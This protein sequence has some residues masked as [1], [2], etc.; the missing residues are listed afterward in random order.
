VLAYLAVRPELYVSWTPPDEGVLAQGA[1]RVMRGE[2]PHRDFVA[3]WSGGLDYLN[4]AAFRVLGPRLATLRTVVAAAWLLGLAAMFVA[5]R[6]VLSAWV[7]G[8]LTL[9]AALWTLPLSP[10]P[11]PSWYNL[12]LALFGVAAVVQ[13]KQ[14]RQRIWLVAA[15]AAAGASVAVKIIGLYFVAAVL[16]FFV[17]QVQDDVHVEADG[18]RSAARGYAWMV[19]GG[20]LAFLALVLQLVRSEFGVNTALHFIVPNLLLVGA[21]LWRE[22]RLPAVVE[23]A[24]FAAFFSLVIPF[25]AGAGLIIAGWLWPYVHGHAL[26]DLARGLFVTPRVR[27][28]VATYP[29]PGLKSAGLAVAPFALLLAGAPFIRRPLRRV[30]HIALAVV[31]AAALALAYDGSPVVL[32]T[33]YGLRLLTPVCA[34]LAT[35]WLIAPPRGMEIPK[36]R[37]A[38]VFFLAAAAATGSL[39]QIPFALYTYF[40]YF[41][42]LLA[43]ALA[44]LL[45]AQPAMPRAVPAALLAFVLLF[46]A[47][48]PDSLPKRHESRPQDALALLALPRGGLI[49]SRED[50]TTYAQLIGSIRRHASGEWM[51]V[52]HDAPQVYFLAGMR[53]PTRTMFEVFDDSLARSTG[54]LTRALQRHDVR[55]VVLT[56]PS[57]AVRQ[58]DPAFHAWLLTAYPEVEWV[59]RFEVRWRREP[60]T[61]E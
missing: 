9:C 60:L 49:V 18:R 57:G 50:S 17:W 26:T 44:A 12:F 37:A 58:M 6:H 16:L 3:L 2:L 1:E 13:W 7:A 15:G 24:R 43:L 61:M 36:E 38:L 19:T 40:L 45:T 14:G 29:L 34:A 41:V 23:R 35:W 20:L 27:F 8:A 53:N 42:P 33:W 30:D 39:V 48:G 28:I 10:H 4:A 47:R 52:W 55:L 5:A 31:I 21:L 32:I 46:A 54:E 11:L 51:Y 25:A 56:D 22:W 59:E